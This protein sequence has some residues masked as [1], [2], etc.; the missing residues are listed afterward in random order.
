MS[1][2]V[3]VT[4]QGGAQL[5]FFDGDGHVHWLGGIGPMGELSPIPRP[6][7]D[8]CLALLRYATEQLETPDD[9]SVPWLTPPTR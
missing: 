8:V 6:A 1:G 2:D 4:V 5:V 9:G 3:T 7:R